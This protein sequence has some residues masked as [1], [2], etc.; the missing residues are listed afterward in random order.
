MLVLTRKTGETILIGDEI[1]LTVS[2]VSG[3]RVKI[4]V[5]APR[6]CAIRRSEIAN[7]DALR[8]TPRIPSGAVAR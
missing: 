8:A 6:E 5:D 4:C 1:R 3:S 7:P 2:S